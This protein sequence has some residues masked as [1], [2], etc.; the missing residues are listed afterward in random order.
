[1]AGDINS[2]ILVWLREQANADHQAV[3]DVEPLL[4]EWVM[5][6]QLAYSDS[7]IHPAG[8]VNPADS[9]F[10]GKELRSSNWNFDGCA[11]CHGEDFTGGK[12]N[13]SC[14]ACH[15]DGPQGCTTCHRDA[16][17]SGAHDLHLTTAPKTGHVLECSACHKVPTRFTDV[18]HVFLADGSP[19]P[20]PAEVTLGAE[21][22]RDTHPERRLGPPTFDGVGCSNIYCHGDTLGD[23][24]ASSRV[25]AW[26]ATPTTAT[27]NRCHGL[28]PSTHGQRAACVKCHQQT[29]D[30][31]NNIISRA[32]HING[33]VEIGALGAT[34]ESCHQ[35]SPFRGLNGETD[36][37]SLP[38]GAH[39]LHLTGTPLYGG[40]MDCKACHRTP[41]V[42]VEPGHMDSDLPAELFAWAPDAGPGLAG[43]RGANPSYDHATGTCSNTYC[44]GGG[45]AAMADTA[46]GIYRTPRW[47]DL[48]LNTVGCGNCHGVPP[49]DSHHNSTMRINSC[50]QC[51]AGTVDS[52]GHIITNA[53]GTSL[54]VN[55]VA[56]ATMP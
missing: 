25:F 20:S 26:K 21:A 36:T 11:K 5:D 51:H 24:N 16:D 3:R 45:S 23:A 52:F 37:A 1:V 47:T 46:P 53:D 30:A 27:C 56:N 44:H 29:V 18:G 28:P 34:C 17:R 22:A 42:P 8:W 38:A 35:S 19:D 43:A 9:E 31:A 40:K 54:H 50:V 55:G 14:F 49:G 6:C 32:N 12:A 33:V 2:P 41:T 15:R 13:A 48:G 7:Q 39:D 4:Q 10:H